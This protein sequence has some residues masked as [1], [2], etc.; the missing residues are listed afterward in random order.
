MFKILTDWLTGGFDEQEINS[1]AAAISISVNDRIITYVNDGIAK[2]TRDKIFVSAY[3]LAMWFASN[4][5][6]LRWEPGL[7]YDI[8]WQL[9]HATPSIGYGYIWPALTIQSDGEAIQLQM[10][11]TELSDGEP[12]QYINTINEMIPA[13][14]FENEVGSFIELVLSRL[15]TLDISNSELHGLWQEILAELNDEEN[16]LYRKTEALLGTNPDDLPAEVVQL[17]L[18]LGEEVGHEAAAE[19]ASSASGKDHK[20]ILE[21]IQDYAFSDGMPVFLDWLNDLHHVAQDIRTHNRPPW[22]KGWEL[23]RKTRTALGL[24]GSPISDQYFSEILHTE[25]SIWTNIS[26]GLPDLGLAIRSEE[27]DHLKLL[28]NKNN[29]E[30]RR[31]EVARLIADHLFAIDD[32]WLPATNSTT[33]RQKIQRAFAAEFLCPVQSLSEKLNG[34]ITSERI[35]DVAR[36]YRVSPL[37]VASHLANNRIIHPSDVLSLAG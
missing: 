18:K 30:G 36:E 27:Q 15:A 25:P 6:R 16:Y 26:T 2:T 19:I 22:E 21:K 11:P 8:D 9:A 7:R 37:A 20:T 24:N 31:F 23:A 4:W 5:W 35:T 1:T 14:Q 12:I 34:I 13:D 10:H 17:F 32:T 29:L 3:P 33:A 28:L